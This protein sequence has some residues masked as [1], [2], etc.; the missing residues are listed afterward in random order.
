MSSP[1]NKTTTWELIGLIAALVIV[2][3]LPVYYFSV[4]KNTESP[5]TPSHEANFVGSVECQD[6]HKVE[7]DKWLGSHHDLAMGVANENTVLGDFNNADITIHGITSRFYTKDG[8]YFVHTNG[9]G[10]EMGDFEIT[11]TFGWYPLQQYL[12]PFPGGRLQTLHIAWNSKENFWFRVP[13]EGPIEPDDWLYWT[14]AAQNWNGMCAQCHSTNLEKNYDPE[15]GTYSTTWSDIDVGC[16]ACHGAGSKHVEWAQMSDMARPT[17]SNYELTQ[18]TSNISSREHVELC[19]PCH[20]RRGTMADDTHA[21]AD[22]LKNYLPS[23]LTENLYF[24]DGQIEDEVYVYGSFTQSKMYRHDVRCSDCHDVHTI[25]L[26]KEGNDL[27]LQCHRADQYDSKDH[28]FHKQEGE[29]G[30]AVMSAEGEVLFEVGTGAQCVQCHMPGRVYMGADYRPDHSFRIPDPA[31]SAAIGSPDACLRCHIDKDSQWSQD[32]VLEWYGPGQRSHYG[33]T[34]A[35][36]R[37]GDPDAGPDLL[38]LAQDLL[39]PVNVRATALSMLTA[40]PGTETTQAMEIALM[41]E[42]ALIRR[43]A[44]SAIFVPDIERLAKLIAPL[45]YDPVKTVRIEAASRLNGEMS[46]LLNKEQQEVFQ[47]V[48]QEYIDSME[49]SADFAASRHNLANLYSELGKPDDAVMQY[50]QAIRID[51]RFFPAKVNLAVLY[52]QRGQNEKAERLL[53][54]VV[55]DEPDLYDAAYSLGLLLVEM[56]NYREAVTYLENASRGLPERARIRYNLGLLYAHLQNV[57]AAENQLRAALD[58]E[59][60]SLDFQYGLAD[61]YLKRGMFEQARPIV[62]DMV[63]MHPENPIGTQMLNFIRT[64]TGK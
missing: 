26:V 48:L 49:Y 28:H 43:T 53:R 1:S 29:T 45:L 52:S 54:E 30:E 37:Q 11:H 17:V 35:R 41:D 40:Y 42:E 7:Y 44:V 15:T 51:N 19:A 47:V 21:K 4:V 36:A 50:E 33:T 13:P 18:Q 2:A 16:E 12:V 20:S 6:C 58:L 38:R 3:S 61:F 9:P 56:Q 14:N 27:C 57:T 39:Y 60:Q 64:N 63:S 24:A 31:L 22:L 59:P 62:E 34:I 23:L 32:S 46:K 25:K 55:R 10:G 5:A 8:K